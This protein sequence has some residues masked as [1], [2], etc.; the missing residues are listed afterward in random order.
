[1]SEPEGRVVV[2]TGAG[3]GLGRAFATSLADRGWAVAILDLD[4]EKA[5][6]VAE[7]IVAAGGTA[8]AYAADI[9]DE[10]RLAAVV[11]AISADLGDPVGLVNNAALFSELAMGPFEQ[12]DAATW[13]RVMRVNVTGTFLTCRAFAPAMRRRGYG[14]IVNVSSS[15]VFTGRGG[16]LHYVTSKAALIGMTRSLATELGQDGVRV[17]VIAPGSTE[18]EIERTTI[19]RADRERLA[20]QTALGRVQV[21]DDLIG[22]VGFLLSDASDFVT[23]QTI[24]VDGGLTFH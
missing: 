20:A 12:I 13:D 23:G 7:Q 5:S 21:P 4:E 2:V 10:R 3:Q 17:N 24:V 9:S 14:K 22:V 1:M 6:R 8:L 18:T 16:Y 19:S 11:S 15:T